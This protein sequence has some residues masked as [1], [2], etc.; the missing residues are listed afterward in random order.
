MATSDLAYFPYLHLT[1]A[2]HKIV[3]AALAPELRELLAAP[4]AANRST[5]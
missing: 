5:K 2:G 3:A 4:A 1:R